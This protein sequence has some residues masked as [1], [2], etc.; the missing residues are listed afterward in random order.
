MKSIKQLKQEPR[1]MPRRKYERIP[2][3]LRSEVLDFVVKAAG[4]ARKDPHYEK[5]D[6]WLGD[7]S[8]FREFAKQNVWVA[9]THDWLEQFL[10]EYAHQD[11]RINGIAAEVAVQ[12]FPIKCM[13]LMV[14]CGYSLDQ[15]ALLL[16]ELRLTKESLATPVELDAQP[17]VIAKANILQGGQA[18]VPNLGD[19]SRFKRMFYENYSFLSAH[20][21]IEEFSTQYLGGEQVYLDLTVEENKEMFPLMCIQLMVSV[22]IPFDDAMTMISELR[23]S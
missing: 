15:A 21:W 11:P 12:L 1:R 10:Q 2:E 17:Y 6:Y 7:I 16:K 23:L 8:L 4:C 22:G 9:G 20:Q 3:Y 18:D 5:P 19:L 13:Q 14:A